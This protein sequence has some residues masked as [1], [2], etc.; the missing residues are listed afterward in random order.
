MLDTY[1]SLRRPAALEV[2]ALAIRPTHI[3]ILRNTPQNFCATACYGS[4]ITYRRPS[5]IWQ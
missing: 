2:L 4:S 3:A 1:E 5:I